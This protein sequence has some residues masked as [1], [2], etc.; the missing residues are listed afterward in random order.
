MNFKTIYVDLVDLINRRG[1]ESSGCEHLPTAG[2]A[3]RA[4]RSE[5]KATA[6]WTSSAAD[7]EATGTTATAATTAATAQT[8]ATAVVTARE[9]WQAR[10]A[11]RTTRH[12]MCVCIYR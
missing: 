6:E 2:A 1:V 5:E 12:C 11:A 3:W 10:R 4:Q 7:A 8:T 9:E